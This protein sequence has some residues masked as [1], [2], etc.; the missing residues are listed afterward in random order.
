MR[1]MVAKCVKDFRLIPIVSHGWFLFFFCL[2][3]AA[4]SSG[5]L[6]FFFVC[7]SPLYEYMNGSHLL[8]ASPLVFLH[9][10]FSLRLNLRLVVS[11]LL[12]LVFSFFFCF[13]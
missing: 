10:V 8:F 1:N 3:L 13:I 11:P 9:F 12:L 5:W 4:I 6:A 2:N 7:F